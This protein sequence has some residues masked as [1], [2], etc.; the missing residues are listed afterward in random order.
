[1][2]T[3][4]KKENH[5]SKHEKKESKKEMVKEYGKKAVKMKNWKKC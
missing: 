1:M 2:K 5:S 3:T 4:V